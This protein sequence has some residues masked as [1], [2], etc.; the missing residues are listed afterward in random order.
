[1]AIKRGKIAKRARRKATAF[2]GVKQSQIDAQEAAARR[3]YRKQVGAA[4]GASQMSQAATRAQLKALA[5]TYGLK[6]SVLK[7]AR[8][9]LLG[10]ISDA[11]N[12][13]P[14]LKAGYKSDRND[15]LTTLASSQATLDQSIASKSDT[16]YKQGVNRAQDRIS[17]TRDLAQNA[18]ARAKKVEQKVHEMNADQRKALAELIA[19]VD[20]TRGS[21]AAA[22]EVERNNL[23]SDPSLRK[24]LVNYLVTSQSIKERDARA[25]VRAYLNRHS[26]VGRIVTSAVAGIADAG[27]NGSFYYGSGDTP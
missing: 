25:A 8:A 20:A 18:K 15:A 27:T 19:R 10:Q 23:R 6:G 14:F 17:K 26:N 13:V 9:E 4:Q 12:S 11:Q 3:A 2:Y 7:S 1:M 21:T 24:H 22:H 5:D 16:L